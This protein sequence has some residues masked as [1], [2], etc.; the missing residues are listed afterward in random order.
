MR[1]SPC[2]KTS[3]VR[4][5]FIIIYGLSFRLKNALSYLDTTVMMNKGL[6]TL[7]AMLKVVMYLKILD[8]SVE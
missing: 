7:V 1:Q 5:I 4:L 2:L 6:I 8:A 3:L